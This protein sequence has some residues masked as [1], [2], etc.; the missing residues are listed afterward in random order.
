MA[1]AE[2]LP[3]VTKFIE[4][5]PKMTIAGRAVDA[6]SGETFEVIDP[7]TGQ[8]LTEVP[9]GGIADVDAAVAA[10]R[11]AFEDRRWS[12]MRPGKRAEILFKI[13]ELIKRNIS[14]LS[15]L[16]ALDGGKPVS[17][18][19]G[20]MWMAGEVFRYY[21]GWPTKF[22]GETNPTADDMLVYSLREPVGVCGGIIPWNYPMVMA[23]WKLAPALAFGNTCVLKPAEQT[24][25][26]ALRLAELCLEAGVPEGVVNVV[27][28]FGEE[29]GQALAQHHDVDKIAFT[30]STEVGRKI[31]HASEGNLKRVSLE[32][33][34]KSPNIVFSDANLRR[35]S[36]GSMLG[37]FINSGQVCT[38]GTRILVEK[39]VHDEFVS[40]L[41]DAT[42]SMKLGHPLDEGTGMG[43]VVSEEQMDRVTG[44]IDIGKS[45]GAEV[46]TGGERATDLGDGYFIQP[47]VFAGVRN[48][49]R[50]AQEEIFGPVAAVIEVDDVDDAIATA[51][52]TIYG[53]AAAV[54][55][56]DL[57]KAH[58]VARGLKA[59]T[60][61]VNTYGDVDPSVSFGG[62]KQ[63]G[64]GRE[65]G[66]HSMET[67]TQTKSVWVSLK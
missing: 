11:E 28:G 64:F 43:P 10:A 13:G 40:S 38:A 8:V 2:V 48:D 20:E 57:A 52:D 45:E 46:V 19:S 12:G 25:L 66:V 23:T 37:V 44:Y 42:S 30:G 53:L 62:Y 6:A 5:S 65:L 51:N 49:M 21:S 60:V 41:V 39:S 29:A 22:F 54:W 4:G 33:G 35:A 58:R 18:A 15:Q 67:Y 26:T 36:K 16:E 1:Q 61:W 50:I 17:L 14:E 27:P 9:R 7:S 59:G 3:E 34:G 32:L 47:T 24:P 31:L 55:T 63:S 56:N